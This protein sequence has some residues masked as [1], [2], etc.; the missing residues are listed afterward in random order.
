[1]KSYVTMS[2]FP[3]LINHPPFLPFSIPIL[4]VMFFSSSCLSTNLELFPSLSIISFPKSAQSPLSSRSSNATSAPTPVSPPSHSPTTAIAG[5]Y[6][7]SIMQPIIM[8]VIDSFSV[9]LP[10][11]P[12]HPLIRP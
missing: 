4:T 9:I 3:P 10:V 5:V 2:P 1:M 8:L 7:G 6:L 12:P 11:V